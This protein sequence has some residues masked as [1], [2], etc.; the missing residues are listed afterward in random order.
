MALSISVFVTAP[1]IGVF[2]TCSLLSLFSAPIFA[3]SSA[4]LFPFV[5]IWALTQ[6]SV[7]PFTLHFRFSNASAV[8]SAIDDLKSILSNDFS[9]A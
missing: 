1:G 5:P 6:A 8:L 7:H 2:M 9:A 4:A 3:A